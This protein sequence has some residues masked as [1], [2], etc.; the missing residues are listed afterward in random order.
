VI[1][2]WLDSKEALGLGIT[3]AGG[4]FT[5]GLTKARSDAQHLRD[6]QDQR[7]PPPP[8]RPITGG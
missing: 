2:L 3:I 5:Y 6:E 8:V 4:A 7:P 1:G